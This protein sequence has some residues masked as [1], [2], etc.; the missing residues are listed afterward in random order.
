M[1]PGV[2]GGPGGCFI[3]GIAE[4]SSWMRVRRRS[5]TPPTFPIDGA[6]GTGY[7]VSMHQTE[8]TKCL[9]SKHPNPHYHGKQESQKYFLFNK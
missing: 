3:S 2:I 9:K 1:L 5:P 8:I 7:S 6:N 4:T